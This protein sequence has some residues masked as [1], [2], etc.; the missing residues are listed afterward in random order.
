LPAK[1]VKAGNL[2]GILLAVAS[3]AAIWSF[4]PNFTGHAEP[5]DARG[6]YYWIALFVAGVL[7]GLVEPKKFLTTSLWVVAGQALYVLVVSVA[8]NKDIGLLFP[9]GLLAMLLL[10][11][12]CYVGAF[13]GSRIS[14][15][16][17]ESK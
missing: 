8:A 17:K 7:V 15:N 11:A 4:S 12:P 2:R 16:H 6:P 10:S 13:L 9:M 1:E 3:G 5:W 14:T